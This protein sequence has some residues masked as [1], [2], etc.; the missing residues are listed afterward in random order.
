MNIE[1]QQDQKDCGLIVLQA[2]YKHFY[3]SKLDINILKQNITY[4]QNGISL[5]DLSN[6]AQNIGMELNVLEGDFHSFLNLDI[7]ETFFTLINDDNYFHYIIINEK[8]DK[9]IYASDPSKGRIKIPIER[10]KN[11][12]LNIIVKV[13]KTNNINKNL[14][15]EH[16]ALDIFSKHLFSIILI[17]FLSILIQ[18]LLFA[19]SFYLKYVID[20]VIFSNESDKLL[21]ITIIFVWIFVVRILSEFINNFLKQKMMQKIEFSLLNIFIDKSLNGKIQQIEKISKSEYMQRVASISEVS[22]FYSNVIVIIFSNILSIMVSCLVM[23][24]ISWKLLFI[25]LFSLLVYFIFSLFL[26]IKIN[27]RYPKIIQNNIFLMENNMEIFLN[28]IYSKNSFYKTQKLEEI[29]NAIKNIK[30]DNFSFWNIINFK[31]IFTKLIFVIQQFIVIYIATKLIIVGTFSLGN[32]LLFNSIVLFLNSPIENL[33]ELI[34]NWKISRMQINRLSYVLFIEN[35]N[36][37]NRTCEIDKIKIIDFKD[38][39]FAY[40]NKNLFNNKTIN[41]TD[42]TKIIGPNGSG[43][44]TLLKLIYGLYDN[45]DGKILINGLEL[46]D[47]NLDKYREKIF[48]NVNN[49]YFPNEFIVDFITCKNEKALNNLKHN[50]NKFKLTELLNYFNLSWTYKIE[51]GGVFLSSGQRQIINLLKL[52]CFDYDL[53]LFDEAFENISSDVFPDIKKAILEVQPQAMF[54]EISH[55]KHYICDK[56]IIEL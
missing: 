23:G 3:K 47:I 44:S 19:S 54:I 45:Y 49:I 50:I 43:K 17:S 53:I 27:K 52:F 14:I 33:I 18:G 41:I 13:Q 35:E 24:F 29:S 15:N 2:F 10:F 1:L 38:V 6:L 4:G 12:Y 5:F 9:Y 16:R 22:L 30:R 46:K 40:T 36:T 25:V 48:F 11:M 34:V 55:N 39:S 28:N 20:K 32:L 7:H 56:N 26:K 42:S 8:D 37:I 21:T 51:D 31:N